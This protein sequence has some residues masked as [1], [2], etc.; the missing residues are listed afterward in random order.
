METSHTVCCFDPRSIGVLFLVY[1][2]LPTQVINQVASHSIT[3]YWTTRP[4]NKNVSKQIS[5]NYRISL[6][7]CIDWSRISDSNTRQQ[8]MNDKLRPIFKGHSD[9]RN[10]L[11]GQINLLSIKA[12]KTSS[13][14]DNQ[15]PT[16]NKARHSCCAVIYQ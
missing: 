5:E 6:S 13:A 3:S 16:L 14:V 8:M 12:P 9:G 15:P 10:P 2:R 4:F 11:S 1:L 7:Q